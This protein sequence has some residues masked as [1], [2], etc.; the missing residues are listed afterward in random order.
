MGRDYSKKYIQQ[1]TRQHQTRPVR[2]STSS[3]LRE[4]DLFTSRWTKSVGPP[5]GYQ[6]SILEWLDD[7][8]SEVVKRNI[9][10]TKDPSNTTIRLQ[11]NQEYLGR[12]EYGFIAFNVD[13]VNVQCPSTGLDVSVEY[14][15]PQ[16]FEILQIALTKFYNGIK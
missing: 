15:H 1:Q 7:S 3:F 4:M 2:G 5:E 16:I 8:L 12:S 9:K 13:N 14:A 10:F 11:T 6:E